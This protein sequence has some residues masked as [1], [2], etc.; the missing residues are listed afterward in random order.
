MGKIGSFV[1][2]TR[3]LL[4]L[5][6]GVIEAVSMALAMKLNVISSWLQIET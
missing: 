4:P 6:L 5:A 2:L 1:D 3:I